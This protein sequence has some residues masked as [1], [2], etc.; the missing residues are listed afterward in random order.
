MSC[1]GYVPT[2]KSAFIIENMW[3]KKD[4]AKL[5]LWTLR[6]KELSLILNVVFNIAKN[7]EFKKLYVSVSYDIYNRYLRKYSHRLLGNEVLL[8]MKLK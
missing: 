7:Y 6:K 3:M 2:L 5:T 1:K 4:K 8:I